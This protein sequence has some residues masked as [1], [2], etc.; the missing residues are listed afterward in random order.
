[1]T[2][3]ADRDDNLPNEDEIWAEILREE[4][5]TDRLDYWRTIL[6]LII[7]PGIARSHAAPRWRRLW[8][9]L[10][11]PA[12]R[13]RDLSR[14]RKLSVLEF[15]TVRDRIAL[16]LAMIFGRRGEGAR[17]WDSRAVLCLWVAGDGYGWSSREV[18]YWPGEWCWDFERNS[19]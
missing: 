5:G 17:P 18:I 7:G 11:G 16:L 3:Q 8:W 9:R 2:D 19:D 1:M 14:D 13:R 15:W 10:F 6:R 4:E 12:W